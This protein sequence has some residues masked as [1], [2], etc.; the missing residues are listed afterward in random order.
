[1]PSVNDS[2]VAVLADTYA[3]A[4]KT[5]GAHWN[6]VGPLFFQLHEA[7]SQQYEALFEAAD[8]IAERLRALGQKAPGG[9]GELAKRATLATT[10]A[11][12][13]AALAK[14]LAADHRALSKA[15]GEAARAA[16]AAGDE[17]TADLFIGRS[18]EHDKTA[19]MLASVAG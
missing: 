14:I 7:F 1:M 3:L 17:G 11:S 4:V 9:I 18:Q 6:V 16:A 12:D 8:E 15:C 5:H 19:W 2:L 10:D 13:G